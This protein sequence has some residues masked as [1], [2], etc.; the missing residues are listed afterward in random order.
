MV[1]FL[2]YR[3][4]KKIM[5]DQLLR[6]QGVG[7]TRLENPN[8]YSVRKRYHKLCVAATQPPACLPATVL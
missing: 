3:N 2:L 1:G 4:H 6:A 7:A 5:E 8:A